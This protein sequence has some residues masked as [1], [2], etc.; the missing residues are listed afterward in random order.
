MKILHPKVQKLLEKVKAEKTL[1]GKTRTPIEI[2][3]FNVK[4]NS[5]NKDK[6]Q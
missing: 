5:I 6:Q 4:K 2:L 1:T 3:G